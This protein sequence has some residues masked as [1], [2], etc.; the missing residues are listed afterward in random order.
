MNHGPLLYHWSD[1]VGDP[2]Y[3]ES[4]EFTFEELEHIIKSFGF[5]FLKTNERHEC[6]YN[7]N[8]RSMHCTRYIYIV[9]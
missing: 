3:E 1:G 5:V 8:R 4:V 6:Y 9:C 2:R 7:R